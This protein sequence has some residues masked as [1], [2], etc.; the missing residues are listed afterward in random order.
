MARIVYGVM[1][2]SLGHVLRSKAMADSLPRHEFLFVG[3]GT[4]SVI[5]R[6]GY[7]VAYV[8]VLGT[9]IG[10][11]RVRLRAT[12]SG[13]LKLLP[14]LGHEIGRVA[15]VMKRFQPD[16]VVTDYEFFSQWAARKIGLPCISIDSHHLLTLCRIEL[17]PGYH[18][19]RLMTLTLMRILF[20][21]A[22]HYL[23]TSF[24][25]AQPKDPRM[26]EVFPPIFRAEVEKHRPSQ[27]EHGLVYL[28]GGLPKGIA[29]ALAG[30]KRPYIVYGLGTKPPEGNLSFKSFSESEFLSDLASSAYYISNGGHTAVS[31]ALYYGK[32]VLCR[33]V[34]LFYEQ[35]VNCFLLSR[36]GYG[37]WVTR[38]EDWGSALMKFENGLDRYTER[39]RGRVSWGNDLAAARIESLIHSGQGRPHQ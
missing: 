17:P 38:S 4:V 14:A 35:T 25:A 27:G 16:L 19:S 30:M 34:D 1:G 10:P 13:A 28:R 33:P 36:A 31:E 39:I 20:S 6:A 24:H 29:P 15:R 7:R 2:D 23:V 26:T 8:P 12:V 5:E 9:A 21:A 32:P 18:L 11:N 3:G 37:E 22:S